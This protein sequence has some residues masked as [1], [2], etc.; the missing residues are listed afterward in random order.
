MHQTTHIKWKILVRYRYALQNF[1]MEKS[2]GTDAQKEMFVCMHEINKK[3]IP[4]SCELKKSANF[5]FFFI[6]LKLCV[7]YLD[8]LP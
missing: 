8:G 2:I 1:E 5:H 3:N 7:M 6:I 4:K